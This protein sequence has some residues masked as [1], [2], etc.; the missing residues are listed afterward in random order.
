MLYRAWNCNEADR[1]VDSSRRANEHPCSVEKRSVKATKAVERHQLGHRNLGRQERRQSQ[2]ASQ[3][4]ALVCKRESQNSEGAKSAVGEGKGRE[5]ERLKHFYT[6]DDQ[7]QWSKSDDPTA[8]S[9]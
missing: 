6:R 9:Q 3:D 7:Q 2:Q 4:T 8:P 5:E 1:G